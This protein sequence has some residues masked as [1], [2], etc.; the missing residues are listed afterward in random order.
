VF[1]IISVFNAIFEFCF[2]FILLRFLVVIDSV[3]FMFFFVKML[4]E[5]EI[6]WFCDK[7]AHRYMSKV[8]FI[9]D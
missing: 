1:L 7:C 5:C 3:Q 2:N 9:E 8:V 6:R 4:L